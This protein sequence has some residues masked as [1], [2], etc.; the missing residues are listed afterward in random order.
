MAITSST[1]DDKQKHTTAQVN[2]KQNK[3]ARWYAPQSALFYLHRQHFHSNYLGFCHLVTPILFTVFN[4]SCP[5]KTFSS[6]SRFMLVLISNVDLSLPEVLY[7][8]PQQSMAGETERSGKS[9]DLGEEDM[10]AQ[11]GVEN[12]INEQHLRRIERMFRDADTDGGGGLDMDQFRDAMKKIMDDED[13]DIIFMKVDTN[14]DGRM[15]WVEYLNYM[16]LEYREKDSLQQQ[17]RPLYFPKPLK[18]VPVA[19]CEAIVR[20]QFYHSSPQP[21]R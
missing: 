7:M 10:P 13:V 8:L 17:N 6:E 5:P 18:I 9:S 3:S 16:L 20:L 14:C 15:D 4:L 1:S 19:H 11:G 21:G 12:Q 2:S